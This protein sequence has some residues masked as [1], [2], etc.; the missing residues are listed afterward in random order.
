M[1]F[2][3]CCWCVVCGVVFNCWFVWLMMFVCFWVV[4]RLQVVYVV[5][6]CLG[7]DVLL[8]LEIMFFMI[9]VDLFVIVC[10]VCC[11]FVFLVLFGV[12]VGMV[13]VLFL[14]VFDWV[15]GM[16]VVYFW[17]LWGLLVV[18]FVIGWVYY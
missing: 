7:F 3:G 18:G 10:Y 8:N 13:F 2:C 12:L 17:L 15:I 6:C 5:F 14:I 9:F 1:F 16:C 4:R 11:W